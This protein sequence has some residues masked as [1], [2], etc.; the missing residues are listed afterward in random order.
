MII[1]ILIERIFL[2]QLIATTW[3][4]CLPNRTNGI[5]F[6]IRQF[7]I[8]YGDFKIKMH[9]VPWM[10]HK[11]AYETQQNSVGGDEVSEEHALNITR[12]RWNAKWWKYLSFEFDY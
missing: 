4:S 5:H 9:F 12:F 3:S 7:L 8:L 6:N 1:A 10:Q 2:V 11:S